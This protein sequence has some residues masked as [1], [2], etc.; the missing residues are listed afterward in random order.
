MT[1]AFSKLLPK[2]HYIPIMGAEMCAKLQ[3]AGI[4]SKFGSRS[5]RLQKPDGDNGEFYKVKGNGMIIHED[6]FI[7]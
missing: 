3:G 2:V 1:N 4:A 5:I 6:L 7:R